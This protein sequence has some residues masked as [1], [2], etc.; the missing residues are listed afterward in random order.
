MSFVCPRNDD[1]DIDD[2]QSQFTKEINIYTI[3]FPHKCCACGGSCNQYM[4][5]HKKDDRW[6]ILKNDET[7]LD[8]CE[9]GKCCFDGN[10]LK[11]TIDLREK[12]KVKLVEEIQRLEC[13]LKRRK[14]ELQIFER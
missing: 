10:T 1:V 8:A 7:S 14:K 13:E 2:L 9:I 3:M 11:F 12:R 5:I 6:T 4:K